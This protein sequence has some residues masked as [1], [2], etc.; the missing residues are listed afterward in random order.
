MS[1]SVA[2]DSKRFIRCKTNNI[3]E[4]KKPNPPVNMKRNTNWAVKTSRLGGD[5]I[6][7]LQKRKMRCV[8]KTCEQ[9]ATF[10]PISISIGL[11]GS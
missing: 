5:G 6:I 8:Q 4:A 9:L 10:L 7:V 2:S 11:I 1:L 3:E